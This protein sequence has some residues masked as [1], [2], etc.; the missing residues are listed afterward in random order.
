MAT[1]PNEE[2][3]LD[4]EGLEEENEKHTLVC[5]M[6]SPVLVEVTNCRLCGY[7]GYYR[8]AYRFGEMLGLQMPYET[9]KVIYY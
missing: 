6:P 5:Q 8:T 3:K 9:T 7:I 2:K 1:K 4:K